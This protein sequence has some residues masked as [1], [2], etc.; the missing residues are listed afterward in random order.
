MGCSTKQSVNRRRLN[1]FPLPPLV[2]LV[3][4]E[5]STRGGGIELDESPPA[6]ASPPAAVTCGKVDCFYDVGLLGFA[7]EVSRDVCVLRARSPDEGCLVGFGVVVF[8]RNVPT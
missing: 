3:F 6:A 1:L 7:L 2:A 5:P 8:R 4:A